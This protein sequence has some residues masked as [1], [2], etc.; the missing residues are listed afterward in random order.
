VLLLPTATVGMRAAVDAV[1][2]CVTR[3]C[4]WLTATLMLS[5]AAILCHCRR[6]LLCVLLLPL[7]LLSAVL[8]TCAVRAASLSLSPSSAAPATAAVVCCVACV[9]CACCCRLLLLPLLL[10]VLLPLFS[11]RC[12]LPATVYCACCCSTVPLSLLYAVRAAAEPVPL[13]CR[14]LQAS[15]AAV[16]AESVPMYAPISHRICC[17]HRGVCSFYSILFFCHFHCRLLYRLSAINQSINVAPWLGCCSCH[18]CCACSCHC[19]RRLL[20]AP[21]LPR[22]VVSCCLRPRVARF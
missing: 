12:V 2:C 10:C 14:C 8:P 9:C 5:A 20:C 15:P 21:L 7:S 13:L 16:R 6:R 11:R 22:A 4:C 3:N 18:C 19:R 17:C 1:V